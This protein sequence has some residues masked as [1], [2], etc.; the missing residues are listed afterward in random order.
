MSAARV[1]G[2]MI[3]GAA[4]VIIG[5]RLATGHFDSLLESAAKGVFVGMIAFAGAGAKKRRATAKVV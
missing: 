1:V 4:A 3:V 2:Y 5:H